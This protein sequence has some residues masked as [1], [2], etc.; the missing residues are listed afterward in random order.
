MPSIATLV[1]QS[2]SKAPLE[3]K[4]GRERGRL[5]DYAFPESESET[6]RDH[7]PVIRTELEWTEVIST[8]F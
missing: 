6:T 8:V 7:R 1:S 5:V 3:T 2:R 4:W